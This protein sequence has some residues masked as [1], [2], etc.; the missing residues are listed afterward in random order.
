M[1][2]G[3][4]VDVIAI[5]VLDYAQ[6]AVNAV[7]SGDGKL[8]VPG[9]VTREDFLRIVANP[10]FLVQ[11]GG[12]ANEPAYLSIEEGL[13]GRNADGLEHKGFIVIDVIAREVIDI[14]DRN[15][16]SSLNEDMSKETYDGLWGGYKINF[17]N[18][19]GENFE[20]D[21][22]DGVRGMNIPVTIVLRD[23]KYSVLHNGRSLA[24]KRVI[25]F[26]VVG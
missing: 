6:K 5:M 15:G 25:K 24:I 22:V 3:K 1:K 7:K 20:I 12:N 18:Q 9:Y 8:Y 26:S 16:K 14:V 13:R 10:E 2:T 21:T 19:K 11:F 17:K 23:G 4:V